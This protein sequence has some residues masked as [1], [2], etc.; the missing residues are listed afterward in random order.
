MKDKF[1]KLLLVMFV[2]LTVAGCSFSTRVSLT[3]NVATGD[4]IK[5]ELDTTDGYK[6]SNVDNSFEVLNK[7]GDTVATSMFLLAEGTELYMQSAM[8]NG[9]IEGA[10]GYLFEM[11]G[12]KFFLKKL[13]DNTGIIIDYDDDA[14]IEKL[15][16]S[17]E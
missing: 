5:V 8:E 14:V 13:T 10:G 1:A 2:I 15:S 7:D 6:L 12:S 17:V 4:A 3:Y 9:A 16:F 11:E